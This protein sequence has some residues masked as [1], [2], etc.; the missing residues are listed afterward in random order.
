MKNKYGKTM[1]LALL[2][3]LVLAGCGNKPKPSEVSS[4]SE[5]PTDVTSEDPSSEEPSSEK[6]SS[7]ETVKQDLVLTLMDLSKVYDGAPVVANYP[8]FTLNGVLIEPI[9][10]Y[11]PA[12]LGDD[13]YTTDG[14]VN[15]GDYI[16]RLR[17]E[18]NEK[19]NAFEATKPFKISKKVLTYD[20]PAM[21]N[22]RRNDDGS[23]GYVIILGEENG[24]VNGYVDMVVSLF[25]SVTTKPIT[26]VGIYSNVNIEYQLKQDEN[27]VLP[28]TLPQ[29]IN[30]T[31][32]D[33]Y[34][35]IAY[36]DTYNPLKTDA[37]INVLHGEIG[38]NDRV[39]FET[40]KAIGT[41]AQIIKDGA[42]VDRVMKGDRAMLIFSN[43]NSDLISK[44]D[45]ITLIGNQMY[46]EKQ[47]FDAKLVLYSSREGG[48]TEPLPVG[49]TGYLN[50]VADV[51]EP[52]TI[53][54]LVIARSGQVV[55]SVLPGSRD[56]V[57]ATI[58]LINGQRIMLDDY[59]YKLFEAGKEIGF[60]T[61]VGAISL[62]A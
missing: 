60:I 30:V 20:A 32:H 27:Y 58:T 33:N 35:F 7:E 21:L 16:F 46:T 56:V 34:E 10:E 38:V 6:P 5:T 23:N 28:D 11:K 29:S 4:D 62:S 25:D 37:M 13:A 19:Y 53:D 36:L 52:I 24:V 50:F 47:T 45:A 39:V 41:V 42:E 51:N 26:E 12:D 61:A 55:T 43:V 57:I 1:T 48:R 9:C 40:T 18:E 3:V 31:V 22:V 17:T 59:K 54:K 49:F 2:S 14:P 15:A 8:N 44:G